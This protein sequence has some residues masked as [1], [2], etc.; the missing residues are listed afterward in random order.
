VTNGPQVP[1]NAPLCL[2]GEA[3]PRRG[4]WALLAGRSRRGAHA[5]A[6]AHHTGPARAD[7]A[8]EDQ[9][10]QGR[11]RANTVRRAAA[12]IASAAVVAAVV[13]LCVLHAP[14]GIAWVM[15]SLGPVAAGPQGP[16]AVL[17]ASGLALPAMAA[18]AGVAAL[19]ARRMRAWPVLFAGLI[20]MALADALGGSAR[21]IELIGIDRTLHGLGAGIAMPA[22]LA[23]AWERPP[24]TRPLLA[25]LWSAITV[26]GLIAAVAVIRHRLSGGDWHAAFQPYPWLTGAALAAAAIYAMLAGGEATPPGEGRDGTRK[27]TA[28]ECAQLAVLASPAVGLSALAVAVT[29]RQSTALLA[30]AS[31]GTLVLCGVAAV[32]SADKVIGGP[33]CFPLIG[34]VT[35]LVVAPAAGAVTSL[36]TL[37]PGQP[38]GAPWLPLA[39][40]AGAAASGAAI[41]VAARRRPWLVVCAGL[42]LAAASLAAARI[43]GPLAASPVLAAVAAPL[44]GGLAAAMTAALTVATAASAL[45][46]AS[47]M[48]AGLMTGYL[49]AGSVQVR[50]VA[51]LAPARLAVRGALTGAAG[52]WEL[53]GAAAVAVV[54]TAVIIGGRRALAAPVPASAGKLSCRGLYP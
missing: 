17:R 29:Y 26:T 10:R 19:A 44:A 31:V 2:G 6:R 28:H 8:R 42:A 22:A 9:S 36:R 41:A 48:L 47:L 30:A 53:A 18:V 51:S 38:G 23:L 16:G 54:T 24:G 13:P 37:A 11:T 14:N 50:M 21:T 3:P 1:G 39:A 45:S 27:G 43:T 7:Q 5:A 25:A 12:D 34:A 32:A 35:G 40:A 4:R 20:V 33:L 49:A 15:A 52:L 46:G